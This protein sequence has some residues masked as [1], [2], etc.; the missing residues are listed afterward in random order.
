MQ[1]I[2]WSEQKKNE[3]TRC[4]AL[5]SWPCQHHII[6]PL[7][8]SLLHFCQKIFMKIIGFLLATASINVKLN[9]KMGNNNL[10][11]VTDGNEHPANLAPGYNTDTRI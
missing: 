9:T 10:S 1:L 4:F 2:F 8:I 3:I 7:N 5:A 6:F 11:P